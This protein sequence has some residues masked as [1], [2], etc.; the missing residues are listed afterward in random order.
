[1]S[2]SKTNNLTPKEQAKKSWEAFLKAWKNIFQTTK[3]AVKVV[4]KTAEWLYRLIDAWDL[5]IHNKW[6]KSTNKVVDFTK[7]NIIKIFLAAS[8]LT[9][10]W[11]KACQSIKDK[12]PNKIE[13]SQDLENIVDLKDVEYKIKTPDSL[14]WKSVWDLYSHYLW[15]GWKSVEI[16]DTI[17]FKPN[18][19]IDELY[20]RKFRRRNDRWFTVA[21]SFYD[22]VVSKI[23]FDIVEKSNLELIQ[24]NIKSAINE[25]N[26]HFDREKFWQEKL[27]NNTN[28]IKL[29]KKLCNKIDEKSL[30]AYGMTELMGS[31]NGEFNKDFLNFLLECGWEKFV[32]NLPAVADNYASHW[33]YQFTSFAVYDTWDKQEWASIM[34]LY[35]KQHKIPWSVTKL[36]WQDHHKTAY[37]FAMYN[38]YTLVFQADSQMMDALELL[39]NQPDNNDLTQLIAIMHNL[40]TSGKKFLNEW[41]KLNTDD[42]YL[43]KKTHN[44]KWKQTYNYD[45]NWNKKIDLYESFVKPK[46]S[47]NYWKKTYYNR[48]SLR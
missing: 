22:E 7:K 29:F 35:L 4:W 25:V 33:L 1:M 3:W 48:N 44:S 11:V 6:W 17:I 38:L 26:Q 12:N 8:I 23:D 15:Y 45:L 42:T 9:Y 31:V 37:L 39:I 16:W 14:R 36:Q 19:I 10:P 13:L 18:Q 5:A 28:K 41:Y 27:K 32:M 46:T 2:K 34:N 40:P 30:L 47:H 20:Q 24:E 21:K 43:Y